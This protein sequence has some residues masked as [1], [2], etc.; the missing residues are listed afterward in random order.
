[1]FKR[2]LIIAGIGV[3]L[4]I[5]GVAF[6]H[7]GGYAAPDEMSAHGWFAFAIGALLSVLLSVG[8]FALAF[9]SAQSGRDQISDLS[10]SSDDQLDIRIG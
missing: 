9:F 4:V 3:A 6:I 5:A 10:E 8:L 2:A 1:M 7:F